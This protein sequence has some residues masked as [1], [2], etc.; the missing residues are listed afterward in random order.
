VRFSFKRVYDLHRGPFNITQSSTS[1]E[2][3]NGR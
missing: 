1:I 2:F 3:I